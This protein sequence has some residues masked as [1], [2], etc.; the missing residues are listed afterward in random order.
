[1][2]IRIFRDR[3]E[4]YRIGLSQKETW[5]DADRGLI[6]CWEVGRKLAKDDPE[7]SEK[8]KNGEL[9]VMG[10]KGGVAKKIMKKHK[11]GALEYLAKWQGLRGEDLDI[12]LESEPEHVC[13]L[14]GLIVTFTG[15]SSKYKE[16]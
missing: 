11:F 2:G 8:A 5:S 10:W 13:T 4:P 15:D 9:P 6:K 7:L 12:D 16:A 14:T 1:M 3:A